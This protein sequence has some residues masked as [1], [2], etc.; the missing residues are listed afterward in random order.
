MT[1]PDNIDMRFL[2]VHEAKV[3]V[4]LVRDTYGDTYDAE[5]VYQPDEIAARL[6]SGRLRSAIGY[7]PDGTILGHMALM[8]DE[9]TA[10]VLHAGLAIVREAARGH[11]LFERIKQFSAGWA[12]DAGYLG[13]FSEATAAHP[14]SQKANIA[15]GAHETGF[16]LGWIPGSVANNAVP[17]SDEHR[18]SVALFYLKL[19]DG[20]LRS[21]YAPT[22][23]Q[24][25]V[26]NIIDHS[27]LH[28]NLTQA[29]PSTFIPASSVLEIEPKDDHNLSII[30]VTQV[31]RDLSLAISVERMRQ[32]REVKRDAVYVDLPLQS[33][34][35]Q[36]ML[37]A[38]ADHIQFGFAGV[39]PQRESSGD[40]LRLQAFADIDLHMADI[41]IA[42]DHGRN[43]LDFIVTDIQS[44]SSRRPE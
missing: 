26:G 14:Y 22:R 1:D 40:I 24:E 35:T 20:P 28:A 27:G 29:D 5:W 13:L 15:L 10:Q 31:G 6:E 38:F 21:V 42:S 23:Y 39:F 9:K 37:D 25:I 43:L 19:N 12:T 11:H 8:A 41:A 36:L 17:V 16:L 30:H 2:G 33:P 3:L 44:A 4:D 32:L 18:Q 34:A 7:A